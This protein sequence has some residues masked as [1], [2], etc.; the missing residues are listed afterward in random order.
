MV[1][2]LCHTEL[3]RTAAPQSSCALAAE[4]AP[5]ELVMAHAFGDPHDTDRLSIEAL[6]ETRSSY[7]LRLGPA[8]LRRGI[9]SLPNGPRLL[10]R[11]LHAVGMPPL[12]NWRLSL[13]DV[14]LM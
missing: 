5:G 14:E 11:E 12:A 9:V 7:A 10:W 13:G 8:H 6:H 3:W 2:T 1:T 4:G